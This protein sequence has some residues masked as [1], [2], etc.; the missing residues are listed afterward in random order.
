MS[1][2]Y[3]ELAQQL[4]DVFNAS[5]DEYLTSQT[6]YERMGAAGPTQ[7]QERESIRDTLPWLL[8][9]G[10]LV[11]QGRGMTASF[12]ASGQGMKRQRMTEEQL[13]ERRRERAAVRSQ[14]ERAARLQCTRA[15][16]VGVK[17]ANTPAPATVKADVPAETVEQFLARGGRVQRLTAHWEQM[18]RA[19]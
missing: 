2:K 14:R 1:K 18:E 13:Q 8:R 15:A 5:P 12:K 4:R 16:R 3:G 7:Q 19:A 9:C 10:F 6:L 11:R 17:A